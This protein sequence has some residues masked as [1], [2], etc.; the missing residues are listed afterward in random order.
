MFCGTAKSQNLVKLR[1]IIYLNVIQKKKIRAVKTDKPVKSI[2]ALPIFDIIILKV[3]TQC[4][5]KI[6]WYLLVGKAR[7]N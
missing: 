7:S 4:L 6:S 5:F 1:Q 3:T 2:E